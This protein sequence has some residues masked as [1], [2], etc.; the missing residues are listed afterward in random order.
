MAARLTTVERRGAGR[1]AAEEHGWQSTALLRPGLAVHILDLSP[2]GARLS[3]MARLKPGG[4]AELHLTGAARR[5]IA[6]RISRCRV[7]RLMP[8]CYE[9]AIVFDVRL[10]A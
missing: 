3:S 9:G 6:G 4:R 7:I 5:V 2:G 10:D 1:A 8:L